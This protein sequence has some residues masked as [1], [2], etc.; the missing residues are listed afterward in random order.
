MVGAI[1]LK[2]KIL[3]ENSSSRTRKNF[4]NGSTKAGADGGKNVCSSNNEL[5]RNFFY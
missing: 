5:L 1:N 3:T 4:P 2:K